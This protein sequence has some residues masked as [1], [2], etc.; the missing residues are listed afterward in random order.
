MNKPEIGIASSSE[1]DQ[2]ESTS[3]VQLLELDG[4]SAEM[5]RPRRSMTVG[6]LLDVERRLKA[7]LP[8]DDEELRQRAESQVKIQEAVE[9]AQAV[10]V[11]LAERLRP[12]LSA[13]PKIARQFGEWSAES[14]GSSLM[15]SLGL[16]Q[17]SK[18]CRPGSGRRCWPPA[19]GVGIWIAG[20][21]SVSF[22]SWRR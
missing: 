5:P 8:V 3:P 15:S 6:K 19:S 14:C 7:G 16:R 18:R 2:A 1:D 10:F 12:A 17:A 22:G 20:T 11:D 4:A 9:G 13:Q 21:T